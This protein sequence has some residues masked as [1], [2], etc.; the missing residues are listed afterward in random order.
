MKRL[1]CVILIGLA[2]PAFAQVVDPQPTVAGCACANMGSSTASDVQTLPD[3]A[4]HGVR[5][6][7]GTR[8]NYA[9]TGAAPG[10][11]LASSNPSQQSFPVGGGQP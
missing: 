5:M 4:A 6:R 7:D 9:T 10:G 8:E 3:P 1:I 2:A 11:G